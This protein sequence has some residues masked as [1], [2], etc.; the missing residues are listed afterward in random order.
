MGIDILTADAIVFS[1][2][3]CD[4]TWGLYPILERV[5]RKAIQNRKPRKLRFYRSPR[6]AS[7]QGRTKGIPEYG[8]LI[9][10]DRLSSFGDV[11]GSCEA[12]H[13]TDRV[14]FLGEIPSIHPFDQRQ[15]RGTLFTP[16]GPVP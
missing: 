4:H 2:G 11:I 10:P 14:L 8:P 7:G 5:L 12:L 16:D 3:H 9:G 6:P 13:L 1:H 15:E